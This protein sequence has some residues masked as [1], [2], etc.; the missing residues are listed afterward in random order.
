MARILGISTA[1]VQEDRIETARS[2]CLLLDQSA[3][4]C[5]VI[6][7]GAG[8]VVV[9]N[10]AKA[11]VNTSGNPGMAT[12]GMGDVLSG[13]I[14]ALI[15]QGLCPQEA[16]RAAVYLHGRAGDMLL[17]TTGIGYSATKLAATLPRSIQQVSRFPRTM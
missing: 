5:T 12:G 13:I 4:Q 8:T 9:S 15:C 6:L 2:A 7:K 11:W 3:G 17:E 14:G 1:E 16:A 10:D